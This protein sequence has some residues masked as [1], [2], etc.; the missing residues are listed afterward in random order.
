MGLGVE[1]RR[2]FALEPLDGPNTHAVDLRQ[3]DDSDAL[4]QVSNDRRR[5]VRWNRRAPELYASGFCSR[6]AGDSALSDH[7]AFPFGEDARHLQQRPAA[8]RRGIDRLLVQVEVDTVS[9]QIDHERRH[10]RERPAE[11]VN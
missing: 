5:L 7:L 1:L 4:L 10:V 6:L 8:W 3:L 11:S 2:K 9:A